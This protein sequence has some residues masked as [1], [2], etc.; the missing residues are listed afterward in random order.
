M[1]DTEIYS[2]RCATHDVST[3]DRARMADLENEFRSR[4]RIVEADLSL[5]IPVAFIHIVDGGLGK[6]SASQREKQIEVMNQAF[7]PMNIDF[8]YNEE[9]VIEVNNSRFYTMGHGSASERDCKTQ[10]QLLDPERGLNFYTASPGGGL[11]GWATFP[12]EM[13]GDRM[14]DG[15]VMLH[16]TLPGGDV[17]PYNLGL[18]GVHEVGHWL[19]LYH[20]FQDGC[21]GAGDEVDDTPA[22]AGPNFGKPDESG[23]PWNACDPATRCPINN[24]MNYVDDAVMTEFTAGQNSRVWAQIGMF[25]SQLLVPASRGAAAMPMMADPVVW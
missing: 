5:T 17:E 19:G 3:G 14:M 21:S 15:V 6:I 16:G 24:Y 22:H 20:T 4:S 25:R 13:A 23:Q 18:T 10:H 12:F 11:L 9:E 1:A 7:L 8:S 2:R